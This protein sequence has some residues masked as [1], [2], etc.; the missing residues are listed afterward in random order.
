LREYAIDFIRQIAPKLKLEELAESVSWRRWA[1]RTSATQGF[2]DEIGVD[3]RNRIYVA[4]IMIAVSLHQLA[5][6]IQ[7][8][9]L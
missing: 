8:T 9:V 6:S 2:A 7:L 5:V 1:E 3:E 4:L